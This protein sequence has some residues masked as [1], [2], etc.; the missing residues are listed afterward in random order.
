MTED[1]IRGHFSYSNLAAF[2]LL[3][4]KS[5]VAMSYVIKSIFL[6]IL[7]PIVI[8]GG[9]ALV[10]KIKLKMAWHQIGCCCLREHI[11]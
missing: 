5:R 11:M 1:D 8:I 2:F 6:I 10:R 4:E 3:E 7:F 9:V